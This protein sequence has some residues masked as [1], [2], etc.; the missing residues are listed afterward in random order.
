M[1]ITV[2]AAARPPCQPR[3]PLRA[4]RAAASLPLRR[5]LDPAAYGAWL[6][7]ELQAAG[8]VF[9]KI[10]QWVSSR[11]DIFGAPLAGALAGLRAENP[12]EA[13][14]GIAQAVAGLEGLEG[15]DPAAPLSCGSVAQVHLAA[16]RG[17]PA[18]V[19]VLRPGVRASIRR[20]LGLARFLVARVANDA[21]ANAD[22]LSSLDALG[23]SLE[24]ETDLRREAAAMREFEAFYA[25]RRAGP[26]YV[27]VPAVLAVTDTALVMSYEPSR[28]LEPGADAGRTPELMDLLLRQVFDLGLVHADM[29]AGNVGVGPGGELVLYDFGAVLRVPPGVVD[30]MKQLCVAYVSGGDAAS[31]VDYML[32]YGVLLAPAGLSRG[33]RRALE[34]FVSSLV[35]YVE[36][37]DVRAFIGAAR[38]TDLDAGVASFCPDV[39][40]LGRTFTLMEGLCKTLDPGFT[41]SGAAG[42]G[43]A[44]AALVEDP[45]VLRFKARDDLVRV[46]KFLGF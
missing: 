8:C 16:Y 6:R 30:C 21:R 17:A 31:L 18:A 19:K 14:A 11:D 26:G 20:D 4:L 25:R 2:R 39:L 41:P 33:Q 12:A 5:F 9:V 32:D 10:G 42:E 28:P 44:L 27:R 13:P 46:V 45:D 3:G 43:S 22:I 23:D 38:R 40:A 1:R 15:F 34:A 29:H 24:A 7:R 35:A 37:S 36:D